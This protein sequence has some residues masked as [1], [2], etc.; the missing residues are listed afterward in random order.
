MKADMSA[1]GVTEITRE[2]ASATS[3]GWFFWLVLGAVAAG[4]SGQ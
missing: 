4:L 1:Y 3:G 2:E